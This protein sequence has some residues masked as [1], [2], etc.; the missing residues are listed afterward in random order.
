MAQLILAL[1]VSGI[2][3]SV[4]AALGSLSSIP[5]KWRT[6]RVYS[7]YVRSAVTGVVAVP[8]TAGA[9]LRLVIRQAL[10]W[11]ESRSILLNSVAFVAGAVVAYVWASSPRAAGLSRDRAIS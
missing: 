4:S 10:I 6:G 9:S 7:L 8:M 2:V 5:E 3:A 11:L 1:I